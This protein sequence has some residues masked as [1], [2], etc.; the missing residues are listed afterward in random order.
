MTAGSPVDAT[1]ARAAET[2]RPTL[3]VTTPA[4][5][6]AFG[7]RDRRTP[8][9]SRAREAARCR[10]YAPVERSVGGRAAAYTGRTVAFALAAPA[11][12]SLTA[13][14]DRVRSRLADALS[15]LGARVEAGEPPESFCPGNGLRAV[16]GG[17]LAGL[18][19]RVR[20]EVAAVAGCVLVDDRTA[21]RAVL[22]P[23]YRALDLPFDP[24]A[25]G[26][27][28]SAGAA[29]DPEAVARALRRALAPG[30]RRSER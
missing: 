17:K 28:A 27:L 20:A 3:R 30:E 13:R 5:C 19:Q 29:V 18:A 10:G 16:D 8:G 7:P 6:V 26:D 4:P 2:G 23:V 22:T 15:A 12:E 21:Q 25:V 11:R 9:Y 1:L 24:A 14:Y